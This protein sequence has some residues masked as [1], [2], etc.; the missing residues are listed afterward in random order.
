M[1][2]A[3]TGEQ[4]RVVPANEASW[5]DVQAVFGTRGTA[6]DCQCQWFKL[7]H[8]EWRELP[9]QELEF[10]ERAITHCDEP[11][12]ARTTGLV[13]FLDDEP[14]AWVA[15]E[16]RADYVRLRSMRIPWLGRDGEDRDD[17]GVWAI[18]CFVTRVG[19]RKR[20][21]MRTLAAAAVDFA[22][23]R[24][25]TAIEGYPL[26][27]QP[28]E[29]LSWGELFVGAASTFA[30]AGFREVSRPSERRAVMRIDF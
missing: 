16:P 20:G 11:G 26:V 30:A 10:R 15:V 22:R 3:L 6:H 17:P 24:G 13:A 7:S 18:T 2:E 23:A 12:A 1:A 29:K 21:L 9:V 14:A 28:G 5:S 25:A 19:Y 4:V 27:L 8:R